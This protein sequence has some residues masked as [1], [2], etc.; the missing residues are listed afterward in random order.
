[1]CLKD[2]NKIS[3]V[4]VVCAASVCTQELN[5]QCSGW[6]Q[7]QTQTQFLGKATSF[8]ASG[9]NFCCNPLKEILEINS[10]SFIWWGFLFHHG[11]SELIIVFSLPQRLLQQDEPSQNG[12]LNEL[13]TKI[14]QKKKHLKIKVLKRK[15]ALLSAL[16]IKEVLLWNKTWTSSWTSH[17][18]LP[19]SKCSVA[20]KKSF[21]IVKCRLLNVWKEKK[22][23]G[24]G[25]Q[26]IGDEL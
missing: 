9:L 8:N 24:S 2:L 6:S 1:M 21:W 11:K 20:K 23:H 10:E 15:R 17:T 26:S 5:C 18:P 14:K 12:N 16:G 7:I 13:K 4:Q 22:N 19:P 25:I 3:V